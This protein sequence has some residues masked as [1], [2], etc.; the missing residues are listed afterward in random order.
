MAHDQPAATAS[1]TPDAYT[2]AEVELAL[3]GIGS[4]TVSVSVAPE[5]GRL[6]AENKQLAVTDDEG[7][8]TAVVDVESVVDDDDQ[9]TVS[10]RARPAAAE[11]D[12]AAERGPHAAL[13]LP[14]GQVDLTDPVAVVSCD[15]VDAHALHA[16]AETGR[17]V[18]LVVLSGPRAVA[19]PDPASVT[20]AALAARDRLRRDGRRADVVVVPGPQY[21]DERD[22]ALAGQIAAAYGASP[23]AVDSCP[24]RDALRE[25]LDG[26]AATPTDDWP[27]ASLDAWR[28]WRP[29]PHE[30]GVVLFFTGL[31]GSGK[32]TV[33]RAVAD[34]LAELGSRKVTLLDGDV[35]RR[36]LSAGLG[37]SR[38]DRDRNIERIGYVAAEIARH[39]GMTICAPI[40]PFAA[41]RARVRQLVEA[42]G[43]FLL[44]HVATPL[45][46]CERR[47]R[48][49]LY[50]RARAGQI[51]DFTGISS[52]YETPDDADLVL[53]TS[54]LTIAEARDR[55]IA[56]LEQ[57][58]RL[59]P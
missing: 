21:D 25:W 58:H 52:P 46:E 54:T 38:A 24:D 59:T 28:R 12:G 37:F 42:H 10:G 31:S 22:D 20:E 15:P 55:V 47:D 49:G 23:V 18:L 1:T 53:D 51:P 34:R 39:G 3:L 14:P 29:L 5:V 40:A 50:A 9:V 48:K 19:G 6:A 43:D 33:A 27:A 17:D 56:L 45:E 2:L 35:V 44:V 57:T 13:R 36:N 4:E 41:T 30:R 26:R 8:P 32:S 16:A 7:A 11:A